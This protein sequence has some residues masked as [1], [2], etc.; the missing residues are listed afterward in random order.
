MTAALVT[1]KTLLSLGAVLALLA[2]FIWALRRGSLRLSALAPRGNRRQIKTAARPSQRGMGASVCNLCRRVAE[3][4]VG[5]AV[6]GCEAS[7]C[8]ACAER[9]R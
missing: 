7:W 1:A 6:E 5:H 2:A 9:D 8:K 3:P 4:D